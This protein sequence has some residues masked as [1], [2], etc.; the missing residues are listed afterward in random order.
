MFRDLGW[1]ESEA[2]EGPLVNIDLPESGGQGGEAGRLGRAH[3]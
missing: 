3:R 2:G 1:Q